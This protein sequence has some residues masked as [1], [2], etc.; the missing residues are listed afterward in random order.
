MKRPPSESLTGIKRCQTGRAQCRLMTSRT[1][2]VQAEVV[3]PDG[4]VL[5]RTTTADIGRIR[6]CATAD[7]TIRLPVSAESYKPAEFFALPM[8]AVPVAPKN[9]R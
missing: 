9:R 3:A 4:V 2:G 1:R 6:D 8:V 7:T 5:L